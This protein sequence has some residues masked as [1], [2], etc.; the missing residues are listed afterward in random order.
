MSLVFLSHNVI[1]ADFNKGAVCCKPL[2]KQ[3][4]SSVS[5]PEAG[6]GCL[7]SDEGGGGTQSAWGPVGN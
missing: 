7:L 2:T 3:R 1:P 5:K 6:D 4:P